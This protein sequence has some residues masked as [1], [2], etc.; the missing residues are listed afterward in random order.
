MQRSGQNCTVTEMF[1]TT[2][3][4]E[5]V[6]VELA[7]IEADCSEGDGSTASASAPDWSRTAEARLRP[8]K[9]EASAD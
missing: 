8:L 2:A 1:H 9:P 6:A 4:A 7:P 5:I 3:A